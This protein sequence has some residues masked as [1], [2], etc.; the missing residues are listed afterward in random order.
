VTEPGREAAP[1]IPRFQAL[2]DL[3]GE[4]H[5]VCGGSFFRVFSRVARAIGPVARDVMLRPSDALEVARALG[6]WVVWWTSG[7]AE[8][9]QSDWYAVVCRQFRP[10]EQVPSGDRRYIRRGLVNCEI[11][12][13]DADYVSR[14]GYPCYIRS[15]TR[16]RGVAR[17]LW[18]EAAFRKYF[19]AARDFADITHF[20]GAF[21]DGR[22][23][24]L[25]ANDVYEPMEVC[26]WMLRLDPEY[27]KL[28]PAYALFHTLNQYY[29]DQK[30]FQLI[31]D[32][33]RSLVHETEVQTFLVKK[34][35]FER[36]HRRLE[37]YYRAPLGALVRGT[38]WLG[39]GLGRLDQRLAAVY[40][41]ERLRRG[42]VAPPRL[43]EESGG[44][45]A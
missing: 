18:D 41:L 4:R 42:K 19:L 14:H 27:L 17:T 12:Q 43:T 6:A 33:W 25:L 38:A 35:G 44:S 9:Q 15:F 20:W 7:P 23:V 11:R 8:P 16:Y 39:G 40:A 28:Y 13:L 26:G 37:V 29:L 10:L 36:L 45:E 30:G 21:A 3:R 32:G 2:C 31:N 1:Y 22:L 34:F 24:A 5:F